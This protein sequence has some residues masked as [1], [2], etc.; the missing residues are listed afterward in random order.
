M[1]SLRMFCALSLLGLAA[2]SST[3][4]K[5]ASSATTSRQEYIA[6]TEKALDS[7]SEKA[8]KLSQDRMIQVHAEI[9]DARTELD[10][11]RGASD[12]SWTRSRSRVESRLDK[13]R[14]DFN[15]AR[16]AE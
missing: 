12:E 6:S 14:D 8:N 11:L 13:I 9:A 16:R 7:W 15:T 3:T 4:T 5:T 1:K 10:S 2:C